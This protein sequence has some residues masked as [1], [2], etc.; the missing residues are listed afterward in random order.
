M[1]FRLLGG[2]LM[3]GQDI[4]AGW[5]LVINSQPVVKMGPESFLTVESGEEG[6]L[7]ADN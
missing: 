2:E 1:E 7:H 3:K 4:P 6:F 5:V